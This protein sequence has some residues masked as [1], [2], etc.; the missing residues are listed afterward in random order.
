MPGRHKCPCGTDLPTLRG[1]RSHQ[2][3][4]RECRAWAA[5]AKGAVSASSSEDEVLEGPSHLEP[6]TPPLEPMQL[7]DDELETDDINIGSPLPPDPPVIQDSDEETI[8]TASSSQKR[9]YVEDLDD[10]RDEDEP[11]EAGFVY[12]QEFP[13][14]FRAGWKK[15]EVKTQFEI[16]RERQKAEGQEPW[17]PFPSEDEWELARWLVESAASQSKID[18]FLKLKA[19]RT[20]LSHRYLSFRTHNQYPKDQRRSTSLQKCSRISQIH[21]CT[22]SRAEIL[23]YPTKSGGRHDGRQW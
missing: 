23:L 7:S 13:A 11:P 3:Q 5:R 6:T 12:I 8:P 17:F 14:H 1:L 9:H 19:V 22:A 20:C 4:S 21:R 10:D 16:L 2:S 18:S 15:G